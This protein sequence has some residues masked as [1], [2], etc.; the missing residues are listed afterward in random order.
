MEHSSPS[1]LINDFGDEESVSLEI[2]YLIYSKEE[3]KYIPIP[4]DPYALMDEK[5]AAAFCNLKRRGMQNLRLVG[6]GPK[7]VRISSRCVKYRKIDLIAWSQEKLKRS[8]SDV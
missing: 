5:V 2:A 7:F 8:T 4:Q 1:S 3:D 6:G